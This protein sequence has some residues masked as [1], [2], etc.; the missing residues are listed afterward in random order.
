MH[1]VHTAA[2]PPNQGRMYLP[3]RSCTQKRRKALRKIVIPN[4]VFPDRICRF[5]AVVWPWNLRCA[6]PTMESLSNL[7]AHHTRRQSAFGDQVDIKK[8]KPSIAV[9]ACFASGVA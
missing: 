9:V 4:G 6:L 7:D 1:V 2:A 8:Q 5:T 3:S